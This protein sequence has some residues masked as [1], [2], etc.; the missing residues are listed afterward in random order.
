MANARKRKA[1]KARRA[2]NRGDRV[3]ATP[4]TL[5]KLKPHPL[6]VLLAR[7]REGGGV[8]AD[9]LQCAEEI[10][11]AARAVTHGLGLSSAD[12]DRLMLPR[13]VES[14]AMSDRGERLSAIW[15]AWAVELQQRLGLKPF[16]VVELIA[17]IRPQ[18]QYRVSRLGRALDLWAKVRHDLARP[19]REV[20]TICPNS[21]D[22]GHRILTGSGT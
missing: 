19:A 3:K 21:L 17:Y 16:G 10:V 15:F 22:R 14:D 1:R 4:E 8:D 18:D 11:D 6:E 9:Q 2:V 7:G 12:L 20:S 5:A 13:A